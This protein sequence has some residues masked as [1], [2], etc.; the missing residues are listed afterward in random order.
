LQPF[1]YGFEVCR[2][3]LVQRSVPQVEPLD[4]SIQRVSGII[5][6]GPVQRIPPRCTVHCLSF[7]SRRLSLPD[8]SNGAFQAEAI[9]WP[10][11]F[12]QPFQMRT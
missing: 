10:S 7:R 3:A 1:F 11:Q 8:E 6:G 5:P 12:H 2:K 9:I 4:Q